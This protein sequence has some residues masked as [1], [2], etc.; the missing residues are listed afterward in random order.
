MNLGIICSCLP[1]LPVLYQHI[2]QRTR[3]S[4]RNT[5][6]YYQLKG[7][8]SSAFGAERVK[9]SHTGTAQAEA[10][11]KAAEGKKDSGAGHATEGLEISVLG[12]ANGLEEGGG[13]WDGDGIL[14]TVDVEQTGVSVLDCA[15]LPTEQRGVAHP[16]AQSHEV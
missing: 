9:S 4:V 13:V 8:T 6:T 10:A 1:I 2:S 15:A 5:S 12:G 14:K 3:A 7:L 11:V 16:M